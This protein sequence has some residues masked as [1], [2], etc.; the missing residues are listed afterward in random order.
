MN[1]Y[2]HVIKSIDELIPYV[3]NSRTHSDEQITQIASS[4]KEFGFTNPVLIDEDD[5]VIAGHGRILGAQKLNITDIPCILLTGLTAAQKKAYII[6]DNQLSLNAG[7]DLDTLK[8]ELETLQE[9][10]FDIDLLGFDD[11]FISGLLTE[12]TEGLTNEDLVPEVPEKPITVLGDLWILGDHRL[13]CEDST[14]IDAVETLMDGHKADITFTSPPYNAGNSPTEKDVSGK[15][16]KGVSS[17]NK[18]TNEYVEFLDSYTTNALLISDYVF[19]NIQGI[20]GNKIALIEHLYNMRDKFADTIIWKKGSGQP[21]M[22]R[23]VLNS[24]FEYIHIFSN[25][26]TRAIGKKD[27]RGTIPNI[28]ELS[29]NAGKE[30]AK[31]HKATFRVELPEMFIEWFVET[32]LYDP[33]LGTGT[34]LIAA[35]KHNKNCYGIELDEKYCDVIINRWQNFTGKEVVHSES[36]KTYNEIKGLSS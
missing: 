7:W 35:E 24:A 27:F 19:S 6:A 23:R 36:G 14:S 3:N 15:Y 9:L 18:S 30:F 4:I 28:F 17:D 29:P 16:L 22:A 10:D 1:H 20:S 32:S 12:E 25:D 34:T 13:L 8:L 31:V 5:G 21:A 11:D 2:K 26:A 33:F